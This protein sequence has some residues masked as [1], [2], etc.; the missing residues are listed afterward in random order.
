MY[1]VKSGTAEI[2]YFNQTGTRPAV[3]SNQNY[4]V[5]SQRPYTLISLAKHDSFGMETND[6]A[7]IEK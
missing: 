6:Q 3:S 4:Y 1:F 5:S 2:R 7:E